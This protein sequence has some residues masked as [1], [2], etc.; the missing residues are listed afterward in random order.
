M[1]QIQE[2]HAD[3]GSHEGGNASKRQAKSRARN[4]TPSFD[5]FFRRRLAAIAALIKKNPWLFTLGAPI[6]GILVQ[7]SWVLAVELLTIGAPLLGDISVP[8]ALVTRGYTPTV[9]A[10]KIGDVYYRISTHTATSMDRIALAV[11]GSQPDIRTREGNDTLTNV[12]AGSLRFFHITNRSE[13]SGEITEDSNGKLLLKLRVDGN[14]MDDA[15][16][17]SDTPESLLE[18]A[19]IAILRRVQPYIVA[20]YY[21]EMK[22]EE[23]TKKEAEGI[24]TRFPEQDENVFRAYNLLGILARDR[25]DYAEAIHNYNRALA[26]NL[27]GTHPFNIWKFVVGNRR[28]SI[29][30]NNLGLVYHDQSKDDDAIR[31]YQTA[32]SLDPKF[33]VPHNNLGIVYKNQGKEDDAIREYQTAITLDPKYASPHNNL[34]NV[35]D[36]QGKED[37]AIREYQAMIALDPKYAL[38]H[39][40]LGNVYQDQGK[41]D[42]AIREYQAAIALDPKYANP[43]YNWAL[44]LMNKAKRGS[45]RSA[46]EK[47]L[48]EACSHLIAGAD[49]APHDPDFA[50]Q[51]AN[52]NSQLKQQDCKLP[53]TSAG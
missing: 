18:P 40:N 20:S 35:Y 27:P 53:T 43:H 9:M 31:E 25:K 17:P 34:G 36:D 41:D 29:P 37:D 38:P 1:S 13:I 49:L 32:I 50:S 44:I 11:S 47:F 42:D 19:A 52:I 7:V 30:H 14:E 22:N 28:D 48:R 33:A 46:L 26:L 6:A 39:N 5:M 24:I 23:L 4:L 16:G 8:Q 10:H 15:I 51:I 45:D 12:I 2:H 3:A 21:Y